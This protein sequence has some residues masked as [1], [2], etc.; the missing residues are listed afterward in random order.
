[1]GAAVINHA[2][3]VLSCPLPVSARVKSYWRDHIDGGKHEERG[4][5]WWSAHTTFDFNVITHMRTL[6][7][8]FS[9]AVKSWSSDIVHVASILSSQ[10]WDNLQIHSAQLKIDS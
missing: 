6:C 10:T 8:S 2:K 3:S 1:M 4:R 7:Q 9:V 5:D